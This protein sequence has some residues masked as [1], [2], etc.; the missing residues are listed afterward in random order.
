MF[1]LKFHIKKFKTLI[2]K[3]YNAMICEINMQPSSHNINYK[4]KSCDL[5]PKQWAPREVQCWT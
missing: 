2:S 4:L 1:D 5:Q 3:K